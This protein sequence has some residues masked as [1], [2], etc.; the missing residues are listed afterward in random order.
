[1]RTYQLIIILLI[2][3]SALYNAQQLSRVNLDSIEIGV[4]DKD[5]LS[6]NYDPVEY[7]AGLNKVIECDGN[8]KLSIKFCVRDLTKSEDITIEQ[9]L[10]YL[11]NEET[12]EEIIFIADQDRAS[13]VYNK[14]INL[15]YKGKELNFRSGN[16][17]IR[18]V[19]GDTRL[20]KSIN[21]PLGKVNIQFNQEPI[22][23]S[24]WLDRYLARPE[25]IHQFKQ[26]EKRPPVVVSHAF[27][28]LVLSPVLMLVLCWSKIGLNFSKF[29]FSISAIL[30]H[31]SLFL[32]F[33]LYTLFFIQMNMFQLLKCLT[34][35]FIVTGLAGHRL[36]KNLASK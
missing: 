20:A 24:S 30:F 19:A 16:Y 25:I 28:L 36:L 27:T 10:I 32:I 34:G 1:M 35:V 11:I 6:I 2:N 17:A 14:D 12:N 18:L 5:Q 9:A 15:N 33:V 23:E 4:A 8:Q 13:K 26:P 7:P 29:S 22:T 3:L 31:G 21:W